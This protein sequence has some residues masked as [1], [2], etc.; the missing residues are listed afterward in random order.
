MITTSRGFK[1]PE[2]TD[3]ADLRIFVGDNMDTLELVLDDIDTDKLDASAYTA[4]D[5]LAKIKTV[6]G[7]GSGL[8][9]DKLDGKHASEFAANSHTHTSS[10]VTDATSANTANMLVKRDA[11]GNFSAGEITANAYNSGNYKFEYNTTTD[12]LDLLYIG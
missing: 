2:D 10:D 9:A 7:S 5:V 3:N 12:T 6:D 8:D 4:S 1:K 11:S